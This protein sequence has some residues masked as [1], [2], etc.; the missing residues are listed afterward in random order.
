METIE[1]EILPRSR[2]F[3]NVLK[4]LLEQFVKLFLLLV[5]ISILCFLLL[6]I[7]PVDPILSYIGGDSANTPPE[8]IAAL[9]KYWGLNDPSGVRYF[10]W[11]RGLASGNLGKSLI[12]NQPVTRIIAEKFPVSLA[13]MA[14]SWVLS[15]FF[16]FLLGVIGALNEDRLIDRCIKNYCLILASAPMFWIAL[17]MLMIFAVFLGWFP[18]GLS[19][20]I[21]VK[22]ADITLGDRIYHLV[23]PAV[24]LSLTGIANIALFTR[25]KLLDIG[26]ENF[27]LFAAARGEDKWM[28]FRRHGFKNVLIPGI[29]IQFAALSELFGGSTLAETVFSYPGLGSAVVQAGIRGDV[30]L[31]VGISLFSAVFVFVGNF[32]ANV[33]FTLVDPRIKEGY[34]HE[35]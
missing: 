29:M 10:K 5:V 28:A 1:A 18:I 12:Y 2:E 26:R 17:L 35:S 8:Q 31:L 22:T 34:A 6:D 15:G 20:P 7:S 32:I 27:M 33:L 23:L 16:G 24:A 3:I 21:G 9:E 19:A 13:L 11:L 4:Y 25:R 14:V 30:T